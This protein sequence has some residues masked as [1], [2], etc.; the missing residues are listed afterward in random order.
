MFGYC[1][2]TYDKIHFDVPV[3]K[4]Q[5][6]FSLRLIK[7]QC[8]VCVLGVGGRGSR[9]RDPACS[10]LDRQGSNFEPCACRAVSSDSSHH[11]VQP[12]CAQIFYIITMKKRSAK[13]LFQGGGGY[14]PRP[15]EQGACLRR[16]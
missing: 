5:N 3:S 10:P 14:A 16:A 12:A 9:D 11:P 2:V 4:K 6:M 7:I 13:V 15:S 1:G 8:C